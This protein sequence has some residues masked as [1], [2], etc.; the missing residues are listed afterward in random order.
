MILFSNRMQA[1]EKL[2]NGEKDINGRG[3][4]RR[5]CGTGEGICPTC[6]ML[7]GCVDL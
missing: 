1:K 5:H 2:E 3:A 6:I 7:S 4:G